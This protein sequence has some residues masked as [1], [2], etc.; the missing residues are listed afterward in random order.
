MEP[1]LTP[2]NGLQPQPS[3]MPQHKVLVGAIAA[4]VSAMILAQ[5]NRA[6]IE[7]PPEVQLGL[8]TVIGGLVSYY[9]PQPR[10]EVEAQITP[11][12]IVPRVTNEIV[13]L[14]NADPD[15]PT[16]AK[17]V[18]TLT[19]AVEAARDVATGAIPP[20]ENS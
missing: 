20:P 11:D 16:T 10:H 2:T 14:A 3:A 18:D 4:M 17:V 6:G 12:M 1:R 5:M 15:N 9:L 13:K 8:P 7:P 19:S